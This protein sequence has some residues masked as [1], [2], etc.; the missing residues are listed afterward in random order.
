MIDIKK[1]QA[2]E[3]RVKDGEL[4]RIA[5]LPPKEQSDSMVLYL[6][7]RAQRKGA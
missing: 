1:W 6:K 2:A 7:N 4:R 3:L 5:T